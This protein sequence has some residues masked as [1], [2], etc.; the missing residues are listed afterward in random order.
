MSRVQRVTLENTELRSLNSVNVDEEYHISIA[1]PESYNREEAQDETY[2]VVYLLDGNWV[3][4]GVRESMQIMAFCGSVPEVIIAGIGYP[5][6]GTPDD[7]FKY[8]WGRRSRDT[9]PVVDESSDASTRQMIGLD[10]DAN[11]ATSGGSSQF[12]RFIRE[13]LAPFLESTYRVEPKKRVVAG[14]SFAALFVL[15]AMFRD[16]TYFQGYVAA[17]PSLWFAD[18]VMFEVEE[19]Y[20]ADHED[21]PSRLYLSVGDQEENAGSRMASNMLRFH[22]TLQSREYDKLTLTRQILQDLNH[23]ESRM[24]G[25]QRGLKWAFAAD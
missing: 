25:L 14:H 13:E 16:P 12:L 22:A 17:S 9:T 4:G 15:D 23:C 6:Q 8:I 19:A 21:L 5:T 3:L 10:P 20:A 18:G 24:P 1:L 2:P 7:S 11:V